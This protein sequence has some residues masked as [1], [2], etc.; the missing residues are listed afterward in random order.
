MLKATRAHVVIGRWLSHPCNAATER[1]DITEF[2]EP[3]VRVQKGDTSCQSSFLELVHSRL[4][5]TRD[6]RWLIV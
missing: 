5:A 3:C 2:R 4:Q 6:R 1:C